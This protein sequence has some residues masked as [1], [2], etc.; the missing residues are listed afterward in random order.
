MARL[1]RCYVVLPGIDF[2]HH[3]LVIKAVQATRPTSG[4][5]GSFG[6]REGMLDVLQGRR[7]EDVTEVRALAAGLVSLRHVA[8]LPRLVNLRTLNLHGN[9]LTRIEGLESLVNLNEL[10]LSA[11]R[12]ESLQGLSSLKGLTVL[13]LS[14]NRLSS[15]SFL[16]PLP[17]LRR[18]LLAH[19]RLT[20]VTELTELRG[21]ALERVDLRDNCIR[22]LG[23]LATLAGLPQLR[24]LLL[25]SPSTYSSNNNNESENPV[26]RLQSYRDAVCSALPQLAYLDGVPTQ[27]EG[28]VTEDK[29]V[30][31]EAGINSIT[32]TG[33]NVRTGAFSSLFTRPTQQQHADTTSE[34]VQHPQPAT[35]QP[36]TPDYEKRINTLEQSVLRLLATAKSIADETQTG[37]A[38]APANATAGSGVQEMTDRNKRTGVADAA[39]QT[40]Q[41]AVIVAEAPTHESDERIDQLATEVDKLR[42]QLASLWKEAARRRDLERDLSA[43]NARLAKGEEDAKTLREQLAQVACW[44]AVVWVGTTCVK[45]ECVWQ[46]MEVA[47]KR[48]EATDDERRKERERLVAQIAD[49]ESRLVVQSQL[50]EEARLSTRRLETQLS[51]ATSTIATMTSNSHAHSQAQIARASEP[52]V[53]ALREECQGLRESVRSAR[54]QRKDLEEEVRRGELELAAAKAK[55][56]DTARLVD[57]LRSK[58]RSVLRELVGSVFAV[59]ARVQADRESFTMEA[60]ARSAV[61]KELRVTVQKLEKDVANTEAE[62]RQALFEHKHAVRALQEGLDKAQSEVSEL[63][64]QLASSSHKEEQAKGLL[65]ELNELVRSQK[66]RILALQRERREAEPAIG[67]LRQLKE[68]LAIARAKLSATEAET[69]K[70]TTQ[71]QQQTQLAAAAENALATVKMEL[72]NSEATCSAKVKAAEEALKRMEADCESLRHQLREFND[73]L[74]AREAAHAT[75]RAA[76]EAEAEWRARLHDEVEQ[77]R[78]M[79]SELEAQ[80]AA[81]ARLEEELGEERAAR[82]DAVKTVAELKAKLKEKDDMLSYVSEEVDRVKGMFEQREKAL[83]NDRDEALKS[84]KAIEEELSANT[85]LIASK[86]EAIAALQQQLEVSRT[87]LASVSEECKAQVRAVED[88]MRELLAAMEKQKQSSAAKIQQLSVMFEELR[89][90]T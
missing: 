5:D 74:Q 41:D 84:K 81:V 34:A 25:S 20:A 39:A 15:L 65:T 46:V 79:R 40:A 52:E 6:V 78:A 90:A 77:G 45:E 87:Q 56:A 22:E 76:S 3:G 11:N 21:G 12:I 10:N 62:L 33:A 26:C 14:S 9:A 54:A 73:A 28:A 16:P 69:A 37:T 50:L 72:V 88:E 75:N 59:V 13:N 30:H 58:L 89:Q 4:G 32:R 57:A 71:L 66:E 38:V 7:A 29:G 85:R 49:L 67:E 44:V 68:D 47:A 24:E 80:D 1:H 18:L 36:A 61:E 17:S 31:A 70:L 60:R 19:N 53:N 35:P 48:N 42:S 51:T 55:A 86:D 63:R 83:T 64:R 8:G 23:E 2:C 82:S 43:A 27:L